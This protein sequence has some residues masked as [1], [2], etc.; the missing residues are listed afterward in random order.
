MSPEAPGYISVCPAIPKAP[1]T[2]MPRYLT[3]LSIIVGPSNICTAPR[4]LVLRYISEAMGRYP[5]WLILKISGSHEDKYGWIEIEIRVFLGGNLMWVHTA[6]WGSQL[7]RVTVFRVNAWMALQMFRSIAS[8]TSWRNRFA[9]SSYGLRVSWDSRSL[10]V[11][12]VPRIFW[13]TRKP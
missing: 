5:R 2:S 8:I 12:A 7:Q 10:W 6:N 3:V 9:Q 11:I 1:P 13:T 4:F